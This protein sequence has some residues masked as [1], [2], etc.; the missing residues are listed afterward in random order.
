MSLT[1]PNCAFKFSIEDGRFCQL[2]LLIN[3]QDAG[4]KETNLTLSLHS[5]W[6][7]SRIHIL[8]IEVI[9]EQ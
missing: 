7:I 6:F 2:F 9:D 3:E 4:K 1:F 5:L 8:S